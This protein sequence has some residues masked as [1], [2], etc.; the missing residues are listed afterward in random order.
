MEAGGIRVVINAASQFTE[1]ARL[2][3]NVLKLVH[4]CAAA[5]GMML[6]ES[7]LALFHIYAC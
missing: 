5:S 3:E 1:N 4:Q 7:A 6:F 2:Q